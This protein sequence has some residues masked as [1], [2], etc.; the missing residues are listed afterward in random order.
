MP[1]GAGGT[2]HKAALEGRPNYPSASFG[3]QMVG[4]TKSYSGIGADIV[5][6]SILRQQSY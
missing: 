3:S 4:A 2:F 6:E 1:Y 5:M